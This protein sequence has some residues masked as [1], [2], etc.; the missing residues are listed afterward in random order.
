LPCHYYQG[1]VILATLN[2][3]IDQIRKEQLLSI[4][5]I[6]NFLKVYASIF[7]FLK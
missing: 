5:L 1:S 3:R 2:I 7:D 6:S 4:G